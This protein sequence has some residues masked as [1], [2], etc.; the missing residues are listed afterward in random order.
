MATSIGSKGGRSHHTHGHGHKHER[1][2]L[3]RDA[4]HLMKSQNNLPSATAYT[5]AHA[6][7]P[8]HVGGVSIASKQPQ[9]I[10]VATA[11]NS[12]GTLMFVCEQLT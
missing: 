6:S 4:G 1:R 3:K 9:Q 2:D 11:G 10:A 5:G 7:S 8:S 12:A